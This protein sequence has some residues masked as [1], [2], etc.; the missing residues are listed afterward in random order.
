MFNLLIVSKASGSL[1]YVV[2]EFRSYLRPG[3]L[4]VR[5]QERDIDILITEEGRVSR[6]TT[7]VERF[8]IDDFLRFCVIFRRNLIRGSEK[9]KV[10]Q[11]IRVFS[12]MLKMGLVIINIFF[13]LFLCRMG[14]A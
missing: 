6:L 7:F 8:L 12:I 1:I 2:L 10:I 14:N 5:S 9:S 4:V 13:F 3:R 11:K